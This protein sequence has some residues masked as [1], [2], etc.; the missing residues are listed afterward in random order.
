MPTDQPLAGLTAMVTGAS[1]GIGAE[2]AK[3][4]ALLGA[5]VFV[6][7]HQNQ[8]GLDETLAEI[9]QLGREASSALA[10]LSQPDECRA[11]VGKAW[12]WRPVDIWMHNA[13]ADVLTG[14]ASDWSFEQKLMWLFQ[15]DV[16]GAMVCCRDIGQRMN[17]RGTGTILTIG[18]DQA[19]VGMAGDSG[20]MFATTKGAVMG[21][22]R[23]LAKS[24]APKVRV[25]CIAPGWIRTKWGEDAPEYWRNRAINESL[26]RRWGEP[27]DI[28]NAAAYLAS[29]AASFI[30]GQVFN[31]N[32]GFAGSKS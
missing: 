24:L 7:A 12:A 3:R 29:P 14:E 17:E 13:G 25:N 32:G 9:R 1:S 5:D 2:T 21:F 6:H 28:A 4:F 11:L 18:W 20:E 27:V 16:Q 31:V 23:S 30:T 15:V 19:E 10:D 22:T 8:A 26:V